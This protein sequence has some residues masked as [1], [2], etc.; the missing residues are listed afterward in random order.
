MRKP[1]QLPAVILFCV[2]AAGIVPD[3]GHANKSEIGMDVA[4]EALRDTYRLKKA[5]MDDLIAAA[6][7]SRVANIMRPYLES[8]R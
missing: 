2:P 4:L 8:L 3:S 6:K 7:V 5:T 1:C